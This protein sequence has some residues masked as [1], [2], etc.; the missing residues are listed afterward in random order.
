M[1]SP[2]PCTREVV[3]DMTQRDAH[4]FYVRPRCTVPTCTLATL[5]RCAWRCCDCPDFCC[6]CGAGRARCE[7]RGPRDLAPCAQ[8]GEVCDALPAPRSGMIGWPQGSEL[9]IHGDAYLWI[10]RCAK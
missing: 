2:Q 4:A 6:V 1:L 10:D 9:W 3:S 7:V 5:Y 8:P